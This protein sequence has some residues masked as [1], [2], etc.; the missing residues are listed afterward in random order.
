M[1]V[2]K[3]NYK[4]NLFIKSITATILSILIIIIPLKTKGANNEILE[5]QKEKFGISDF[6]KQS[7]EYSGEFLKDIDFNDL[8]KATI[9]GKVDNSKISSKLMVLFGK[10]FM[11]S[12]H[13]MISILVIII[14]HSI[15]KTVSDSL[16]NN[17]ITNGIYYVQYIAIVTIVMSNFSKVINLVKETIVNLVGF[18]NLLVPL[19]TSLMVFTGSIT[20]TTVLEPIILFFISLIG[21]I[22]QNIL[23]PILLVITTIC[24]VSK[25]S[26]N[27]QVEK[28]GKFLKSSTIWF[29]G[30]IL[31][32]FVGIVSLEGSMASAVDGVTAK[33]AKAVVSSSVP[34]V[35][36]ILGDAVDSVLGCGVILKNAVGIV[37]VIVVVGICIIPIIKLFVV[38]VMYKLLSSIS[39]TIADKKI[40]SVLD[41]L[42]DV[43]KLLLAV[44]T[45]LSFMLIIGVTMIVKISNMGMMYR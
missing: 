22:I 4:N 25:I 35:G 11:N 38:M 2:Q 32:I 15:L 3:K 41:Q 12:I 8:F 43:Y 19:L 37:G 14:I 24:I 6:L 16:E 29:L 27:V 9:E 31:T 10:E 34:V 23:I 44:L 30:I 21:N 17:T 40:T 13:T 5:E 36:K 18:M 28:I 7:K 1:I 20:T 39:E 45:T 26:D 33:T 42:G